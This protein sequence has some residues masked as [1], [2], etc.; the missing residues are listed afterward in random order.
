MHLH[1][2]QSESDPAR[3]DVKAGHTLRSVVIG[4]FVAFG[5]LAAVNQGAAIVSGQGWL[6]AVVVMLALWSCVAAFAPALPWPNVLLAGGLAAF[7][8][9]LVEAINAATGFPFGVVAFTSK[10]GPM[11]LGL[12]P[13]WLPVTWAVIAL[14]ARGAARWILRRSCQHPLHGYRVI[15]VSVMLAVVTTVGLG[16]MASHAVQAWTLD[17]NPIL[18]GASLLALHFFIQVAMTPLLIDKFPGSRPP[19]LRPLAV[20]SGANLICW[21]GVLLS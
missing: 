3:G 17:G 1:P 4:L 18:R 9:G 7:S 15:G 20:W 8:G 2:A 21:G 10:A 11:V 14:S 13:W 5:G 19:S 12:I 6:N 16:R